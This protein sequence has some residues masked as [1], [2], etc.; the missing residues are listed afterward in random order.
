MRLLGLS[1]TRL[2]DFV[3]YDIKCRIGQGSEDDD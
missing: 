1:L 3:N 2:D